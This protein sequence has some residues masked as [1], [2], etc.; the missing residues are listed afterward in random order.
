[1]TTEINFEEVKKQSIHED[2]FKVLCLL[3]QSRNIIHEIKT[4]SELIDHFSMLDNIQA[5]L[6]DDGCWIAELI[7]DIMSLRVDDLV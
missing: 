4:K 6:N 3:K 7:S 2:L 1:M 5:N